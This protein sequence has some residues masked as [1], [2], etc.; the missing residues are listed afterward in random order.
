MAKLLLYIGNEARSS[1]VQI[2]IAEYGSFVLGAMAFDNVR[3]HGKIPSVVSF[4]MFAVLGSDGDSVKECLGVVTDLVLNVNELD[5][6][7][8]SLS[9]EVE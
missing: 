4:V 3:H 2:T 8:F 1:G 5:L 9:A 7:G 6:P